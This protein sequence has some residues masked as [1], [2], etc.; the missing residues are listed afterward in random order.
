MRRR[1]NGIFE[2][3]F[4]ASDT[5]AERTIQ[6]IGRLSGSEE[7]QAEYLLRRIILR[8]YM[9]L[10]AFNSLVQNGDSEDEVFLF[11]K[12]IPESRR[13]MI[14]TIGRDFDATQTTPSYPDKIVENPLTGAAQ[15]ELDHI[16]VKNSVLFRLYR[17]ELR[18][19]LLNELRTD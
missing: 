12:E 17:K 14:G 11:E 9:R 2:A 19:L 13:R 15:S 4:L 8:D 3:K 7:K 6:N 18:E 10:M 16:I 1:K 5:N